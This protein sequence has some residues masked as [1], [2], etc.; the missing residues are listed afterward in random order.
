MLELGCG[1]FRTF[2][3]VVTDPKLASN[4]KWAVR[5]MENR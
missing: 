4:A 1:T 5:E 2:G 3:P